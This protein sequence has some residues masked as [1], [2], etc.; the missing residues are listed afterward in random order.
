MARDFRH[1][2]VSSTFLVTRGRGRVAG[3]KL[4]VALI[5]PALP[6]VASIVAVVMALPC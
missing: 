4:V 6:V 1:G 3:A 2:T 5:G